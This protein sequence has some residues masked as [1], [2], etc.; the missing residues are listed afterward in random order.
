MARAADIDTNGFFLLGLS[1]DTVE[2]MQDTITFARSLPVDTMLFGV[3]IPFPGTPMFNEY[4]K[5]GLIR[6]FD[7]DQ[8]HTRTTDQLFIHRHISHE[9]IQA[10]MKRAYWQGMVTNPSFLFRRL[11][12][13]I[14]TG[15]FFWDLYYGLKVM[16]LPATNTRM[17]HDYYAKDRWPQ[18]DFL[19]CPPV[20]VTYEKVTYGDSRVRILAQVP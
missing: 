9:A 3:T 15:E 7:W 13:G 10:T 14:R 12:R 5:D 16:V 20:P 1:A 8:Y 2:T 4:Y 19:A 6:S 11:R 18:H 17:G